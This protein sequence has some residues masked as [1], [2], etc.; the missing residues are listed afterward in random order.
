MRKTRIGE[1]MGGAVTGLFSFALFGAFVLLSLLIVVIGVDGYR[2]VVDSAEEVASTRASISYVA[3][4]VRAHDAAGSVRIERRGD[5]DMLVLEQ[6][7]DDEER[8]ETLIYFMDGA[9]R[10]LFTSVG[11]GVEPDYGARIA[12]L[13]GFDMAM[14]AENLLRFTATTKGGDVTLRVAL[15]SGGGAP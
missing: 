4:K 5:V 9:L 15:R 8:Y 11:S 14:E 1:G 3:G 2:G 12:S 6:S 10:E 7:F 13:S